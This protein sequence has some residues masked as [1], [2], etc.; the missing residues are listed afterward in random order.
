MDSLQAIA[1]LL[2]QTMAPA[3]SEKWIQRYGAPILQ[4]ILEDRD[5]YKIA[6]EAIREAIY[7]KKG[8]AFMAQL[9]TLVGLFSVAV[10]LTLLSIVLRLRQ[11]RFWLFHRIDSRI[12]MPNISVHNSFWA[13]VYHCLSFV[14]L[15]ITSRIVSGS[16]YPSWYLSFQD[17][18]PLALSAGQVTEVW[19]TFGSSYIRKFGSHH[20]DPHITSILYQSLPFMFALITLV[21]SFT[22][23][24]ILKRSLDVVLINAN[25][26]STSLGKL[27]S[28][29]VP[30]Q[31]MVF[32]NLE[33]S[34]KSLGP[35]V[36]SIRSLSLWRK[37][38]NSYIGSV[39]CI[40]SMLY[41][42]AAVVEINH[43]RNQARDLR[44][45]VGLPLA[46]F[47][48]RKPEDDNQ[49]SPTVSPRDYGAT[50]DV[51]LRSHLIVQAS[52]VE[53][54]TKNRLLVSTL[55]SLML[56]S[57]TFLSYSLAA[58]PVSIIL[59][60]GQVQ[61]IALIGAWI[62]SVLSFLVAILILFRS[63]G[64]GSNALPKRLRRFAAYL[65]L[66]P[67]TTM[68]TRTTSVTTAYGQK[69]LVGVSIDVSTSVMVSNAKS[70]E[71]R[72]EKM[73]APTMPQTR[74]EDRKAT[75]GSAPESSIHEVEMV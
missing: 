57:N 54:A 59:N 34:L 60:S 41:I 33:G 29:W 39:L 53:W 8:P 26:T 62:N 71:K 55:I 51:D 44:Q 65:P 56:L 24:A 43:L 42:T 11:G 37:V 63:L 73:P 38:T 28:A 15:A 18:L 32:S 23:L 2:N 10:V 35:L 5:P 27:S 61:D 36:A 40:T 19:A 72:S 50:A 25:V 70:D 17:A 22:L 4:A 45:R 48:P 13:F 75:L 21:P 12:T 64:D 1:K 31:P 68:T 47:S 46:P 3:D 9:W 49:A 6:V 20:D 67:T 58:T 69:P 30:G 52:L 14:E 66:P 74:S 7:P 16:S